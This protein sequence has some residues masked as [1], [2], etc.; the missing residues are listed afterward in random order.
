[1]DIENSTVW[2]YTA[3]TGN[4]FRGNQESIHEMIQMLSKSI[5]ELHL[6][7]SVNDCVLRNKQNYI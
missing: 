5:Q 3:A 4:W 7:N 1:M 6:I 2:F